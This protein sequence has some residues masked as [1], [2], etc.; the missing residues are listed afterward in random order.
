[1]L[2]FVGK[3][4]T[5]RKIVVIC[6]ISIS[7]MLVCQFYILRGK[8][9]QP[10]KDVVNTIYEVSREIV[11]RVFFL[12]GITPADVAL[13]FTQPGIPFDAKMHRVNEQYPA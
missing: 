2:R 6:V 11:P 4:V 12:H 3:N 5:V 9:L 8:Q 1:L 10:S 13:D 7:S